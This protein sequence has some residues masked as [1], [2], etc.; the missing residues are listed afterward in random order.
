MVDEILLRLWKEQYSSARRYIRDG[1]RKRTDKDRFRAEGVT[2][3]LIS[4]KDFLAG[5]SLSKA[6]KEQLEADCKAVLDLLT[7]F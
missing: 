6:A 2:F 1:L 3:M 4:L 7:Q 5:L